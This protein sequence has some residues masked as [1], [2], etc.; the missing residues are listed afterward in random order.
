MRLQP[1]PVNLGGLTA[2]TGFS[3]VPAAS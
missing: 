1:I 2:G 3:A